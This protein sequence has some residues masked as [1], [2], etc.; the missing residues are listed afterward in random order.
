[1]DGSATAPTIPAKV[2]PVTPENALG[3]WPQWEPLLRRAMRDVETHDVM[4]VRR[5]VLGEHAQFWIQW[6]AN[7]L[8]AFVISEFV[9]YP[10]G[11][12]LRLWIAATAP[13]AVL[14]EEKFEEVLS[15][16]RDENNCRGFEIVGRMGWARRF[17]YAR[18][19][20]V[21]LRTTT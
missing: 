21:V 10:K 13:G 17:R 19:V 1:M 14:E 9:T 5:L 3:L 6:R 8:E 16:F 15:Q 4:D 11:V 12:W 7:T 2:F 18:F 20:G